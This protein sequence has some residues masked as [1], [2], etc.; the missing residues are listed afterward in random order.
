M[1][2]LHLDENHPI[3]IQ[4][5]EDAGFENTQAYTTSKMEVEAMLPYYQGI[6]VRSRFPIDA[7]FLTKGPQLK[8]IARVG[9][10]VENIDQEAAKKNEYSTLCRSFGERQCSGRTCP[11]D[12]FGFDQ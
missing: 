1:K 7:A 10:G 9:A 4:Q 6:V 12:A 2:I 11:R 3:L 8:F 5:L